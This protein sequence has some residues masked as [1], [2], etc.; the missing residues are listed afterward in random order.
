MEDSEVDLRSGL[1]LVRDHWFL[2]I[3]ATVIAIET[4]GIVTWNQTPQ[5]SSRVTFFI[6]AWADPEDAASAYQG[7]LLSEQKV[8]SYAELLRT[9]RVMDSVIDDLSLDLSAD[10]LSAKVATRVVSDTSLLE[11]TVTDPSP[12]TAQAIARSIGE[13]F[14]VIVPT[15]ESSAGAGRATV[16]VAV[17]NDAELATVPITPRPVRNLVLAGIIGLLVGIGLAAA[18][19]AL[20]TTIKTAPE[21]E[22]RAGVPT[23]GVVAADRKMRKAPLIVSDP[24]G[25]RSEEIRK[26]RTNLQ[27]VDVDRPH[28]VILVSGA[29]GGEG[30]TTTACNLAIA[31]AESGKRVILIDADLRKPR[32]A[33]FLGLPIG[34]GLT[35]VLVGATSLDAAKQTWG[36]GFLTVLSS[37]STAPNPSELLGSQHMREILDELRGS[38]DMVVVDG[39]PLL[40]VA[41]AAVT[42]AA[43]DGVLIVV[44]RGRTR[45]E[46]LRE[47]L[48]SLR[49]VKAPVLGTVLNFA[50]APSHKPY[51][52][53]GLNAQRR[54]L[55][56]VKSNATGVHARR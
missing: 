17:V 5:Y 28:K 48:D 34:A 24:H 18:R 12:E 45:Q 54:P 27:F 33:T 31:M 9:R 19:R 40:R 49:N 46:Q 29:L 44:R 50:P 53:R 3:V 35:D 20:D 15:L 47:S 13:Q 14:A 10:E 23:L 16:N 6:S 8:K 51:R 42:A 52:Y 37:G 26:I 25:L 2:I 43:C 55:A 4:A 1:R 7:G 11:A 38:Y 41:D 36:E 56:E 22:R 39:P 32:A 30:K 21:L